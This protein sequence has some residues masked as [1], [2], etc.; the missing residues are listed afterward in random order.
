[1]PGTAGGIFREG[2]E[3]I[4]AKQGNDVV[5]YSYI[6]LIQSGILMKRVKRI[7]SGAWNYISGKGTFVPTQAQVMLATTFVLGFYHA[8]LLISFI[9]YRI[10][11]MVIIN[12]FSVLTYIVQTVRVKRKRSFLSIIHVCYV[13]I[14]LQVLFACM[15]VGFEC[16]F[17]FYLIAVVA[18]AFY[19]VYMFRAKRNINPIP[20][21]MACIL[22]FAVC[23]I[24][25][26]Y[27]PPL[28]VFSNPRAVEFFSI[29]NF[30]TAMSAVVLFMSTFIVTIDNM[31]NTM[32]E[33]N[34]QLD[35]VS[36]RDALTGLWNRRSL[37]DHY[38]I[39]DMK[40]D[41]YTLIYGDIDNFKSFNDTYGH[42][43]GDQVLKAVTQAF[44]HSVRDKDMV[45]RWGGEEILVYLPKCGADTAKLVAQRIL[46]NVRQT[47]VVTDKGEHLSVT[48]TL[49]IASTTEASHFDEVLKM[50][51]DRLYYGKA[52][53]KNQVVGKNFAGGLA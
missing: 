14:W 7:I 19:T 31:E 3:I 46:N 32:L 52:H 1:M 16:G 30:F 48:M 24:W 2:A 13:E 23:R 8:F 29:V 51:D 9:Y 26:F 42:D 25:T 40:M 49:G 6:V 33:Q 38:R 5:I 39:A 43:V 45:C 53:G 36:K 10:T 22:D 41:S 21:I 15:I 20:Y 27:I 37:E 35:E 12:I 28:Y 11:V 17:Q 34:Q 4:V 44:Q 50:A 47:E 18:H